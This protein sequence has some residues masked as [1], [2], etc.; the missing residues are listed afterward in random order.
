MTHN[1]QAPMPLSSQSAP[2]PSILPSPTAI[3]YY[4]MEEERSLRDYISIL[5]RRKWWFIGTFLAIV[6]LVGLYTFTRPTTYR[7]EATIQ[8]TNDNPASQLNSNLG[9]MS[10][11][12]SQNFQE[13]Q[14]QILQS[15]SLALR[16]ITWMSIR[17]LPS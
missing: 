9:M 12:D 2:S 16:I 8:I 4:E 14:Y 3:S 6:F 11:F 1:D 15:R 7:S 5:L 10:W 13:T 17:I